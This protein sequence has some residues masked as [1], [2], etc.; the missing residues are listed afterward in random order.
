MRCANGGT[1]PGAERAS[2]GT[3]TKPII[4][5]RGRWCYLYRAIDRDGN[6]ID[7]MLSE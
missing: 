1:A 2:T 7:A 3:L 6:L 4:K 5:I